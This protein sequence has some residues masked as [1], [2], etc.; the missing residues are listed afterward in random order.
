MHNRNQWR[1]LRLTYLRRWN[2]SSMWGILNTK[3]HLPQSQLN[4]PPNQWPELLFIWISPN[5]SQTRNERSRTWDFW[6]RTPWPNLEHD[7]RYV[8]TLQKILSLVFLG[9]T[10]RKR[11]RNSIPN[12]FSPPNVTYYFRYTRS[13]F[14]SNRPCASLWRLPSY[15]S[16]IFLSLGHKP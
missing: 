11:Q 2:E 15:L 7:I 1:L 14:L 8:S 5:E 6:L 9:L 12:L 10:G 16:C 4:L 13:F 3:T